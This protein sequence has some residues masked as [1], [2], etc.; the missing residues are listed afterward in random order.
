MRIVVIRVDACVH[1]V[2]S[3]RMPTLSHCTVAIMKPPR[4]WGGKC[5]HFLYAFPCDTNTQSTRVRSNRKRRQTK[6]IPVNITVN[7]APN[8]TLRTRSPSA[9][10][11]FTHD[12]LVTMSVP[13]MPSWPNWF[14]PHTNRRP[15]SACVC[16][17]EQR[18]FALYNCRRNFLLSRR[19]I[20]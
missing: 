13:P 14:S 7:A 2:F 11:V 4:Q 20:I 19:R 1:C 3:A 15:D 17:C 6:H 5:V 18:A 12:G 10:I 8:A 16:V 9:L